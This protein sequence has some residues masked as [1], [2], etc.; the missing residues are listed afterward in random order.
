MRTFLSLFFSAVLV[1]FFTSCYQITSPVDGGP[2]ELTKVEEQISEADNNFGFNLLRALSEENPAE[3]QFISP[4]SISM[5]LGMTLNG[6]RNDTYDD[7]KDVLGYDDLTQDEINLAYQNL[8]QL[9]STLDSQVQFDIANSIWTRLGF[10]VEQEFYDVNVNYFDAEVRELDFNRSDAPDIIN[11]WIADK[12]QNK[13]TDVIGPIEPLVVMYLIN[14]IYFN[15]TWTYEFSEQD[16]RERTFYL[17]DESQ[18]QTPMMTQTNDFYYYEDD[19]VQIIDLPYGD[20]D[21]AMTVILPASGKG[22]D[23]LLTNLD[24]ET[25]A[26]WTGSMAEKKGVITLPKLKLE[27]KK[28][29]NDPLSEMGMRIAFIDTLADFTGIVKEENLD[30]NLYISRVIHQS[31]LRMDEEGTEAAAVTVVEVTAT[32]VGPGPNLDFSMTVDRP[33]LM[34]IRERSSNS[35]LFLGKIM[36]P[37]W[38]D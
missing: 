11:D 19:A 13:I 34:A 10:P 14:A 31:F 8:L 16:T 21:Y 2:V 12:T 20:G 37:E 17:A 28:L 35:L 25:W 15:G 29:L 27:L 24:S 30:Q 3:N 5:A 32:S 26:D 38:S 23:A 22:V 18:M 7:M 4:F 33:Y 9:F 6:A 1:F 36:Q